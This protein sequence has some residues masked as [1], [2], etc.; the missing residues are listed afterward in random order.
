MVRQP[1]L[2][3]GDRGADVA[4][5]VR[6]NRAIDLA[7]TKTTTTAVKVVGATQATNLGQPTNRQ[8]LVRGEAE[9]ILLLAIVQPLTHDAVVISVYDLVISRI[10]VLQRLVKDTPKI[11]GH[12]PSLPIARGKR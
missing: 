3:H 8:P 6:D 7:T 9:N 4:I 5:S 12:A 10:D 1:T 2:D 11:D